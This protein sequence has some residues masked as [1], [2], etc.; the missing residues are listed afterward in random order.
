M[1]KK[2]KNGLCLMKAMPPTLGHLYLIDSAAEQCET[3]HVMICS[4]NTQPIDGAL[5][6]K[7]LCEIYADKPNINII[8]CQD[9][10]P[11]YPSECD[12]LDE[13]YN[14]YWVPSVYSRIKE[15]DVVFTSEDY[16]DEF[17]RYLG[18]KHVSIDQQRQHVPV[19]GTAVRNDAFSNWDYIPQVVRSY[20]T[21]KVVIIGPES[22]G[23]S[24]LT[25][26]L[27]EHFDTHY[28]EE[29]G[30]TF[31]EIHGTKDL[32][33]EDFDHIA[34]H[35]AEDIKKGLSHGY[36]LLFIDTEAIVTAVFGEM[37]LENYNNT[38]VNQI[39][40]NQTFDLYLL[41]DV[42]IPWVDDGTRDFPNARQT[43]FNRLKEEL[44]NR[45][46][47][48]VIINGNYDERFDKAVKEVEKLGYL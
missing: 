43:H 20:Y 42:D 29:Y 39:I 48:Y 10:N 33:Q 9:V 7:W 21:K 19:S 26:K 23:K 8:W 32:S 12:S 25:K 31:T 4:D 17:A 46:L 16:G 27:A 41:T 1:L 18:I 44:D 6:Y 28:V 5:R 3:T 30:R 47:P 38:I 45:K 35:H 22:T 34:I 40:A 37:Y 24:T 14:K 13:F 11:Q 36:K 15:L 2:F